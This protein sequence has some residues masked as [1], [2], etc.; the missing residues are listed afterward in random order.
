MTATHHQREP[1]RGSL[2]VWVAIVVIVL[3]VLYVLSLGP[4]VWLDNHGYLSDAADMIYWP[5][6]KLYDQWQPAHAFFDWYVE[7]W[8]S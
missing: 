3:P 4:G 7:L 1:R 6:D 8:G 5:L 2:A